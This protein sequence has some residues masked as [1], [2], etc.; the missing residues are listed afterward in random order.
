[1]NA[2]KTY[3]TGVNDR[4]DAF[5]QDVNKTEQAI[6][7][8]S[9]KQELRYSQQ[10]AQMA[11]LSST[12]GS[13]PRTSRQRSDEPIVIHELIM[14]K[15]SLTGTKS[16][17][18]I[19]DW[20]DD[21]AT[22]IEMITPGAKAILIEAEKM[23]SAIV[24]E[25]LIKH[26]SS[27][28]A[29]RVSREMF[30]VL[31][32][33]TSGVARSMIESLS[34]NDGL[35]AWGLI[36]L[37][38]CN[39][40]DQHIEAEY[41]V[42]C[43]I[44]KVAM[45]SMAGLADL[46]T[47]WEGE[48]KRFAAIDTGYDLSNLQKKNAVYE[49]LP[50]ELQRT[51]HIEV[52]KPGSNLK[53]YPQWIEFVKDWS[54]TYQFQQ[55]FKPTPLSTNLVDAQ[56]TILQPHKPMSNRNGAPN[57]GL[58]GSKMMKADITWHKDFL[59]LRSEQKPRMRSAVMQKGKGKGNWQFKGKGAGNTG[60]K[61]NGKQTKGKGKGKNSDEQGKFIGKCNR[62][63][64]NG[65]MARECPDNQ[66][67]PVEQYWMGDNSD[68]S[69]S[70]NGSHQSPANTNSVTLCHTKEASVNYRLDTQF[71]PVGIS[72]FVP[73]KTSTTF[74][75]EIVSN[76]ETKYVVDFPSLDSPAPP[77]GGKGK[78]AKFI[79]TSQKKKNLLK[80]AKRVKNCDANIMS[81]KKFENEI[82]KMPKIETQ[83]RDKVEQELDV[84]EQ[85]AKK[86]ED[87][88]SVPEAND[89]QSSRQ[90]VK[91]SNKVKFCEPVCPC[92]HEEDCCKDDQQ[93]K[94]VSDYDMMISHP[95][96]VNDSRPGPI[97]RTK[98]S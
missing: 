98:K 91:R 86:E 97:H 68:W 40:D 48:I 19:D 75:L 22:D 27:A 14:N 62:C 11:T 37:N 41:K 71:K 29:F 54:R 6:K 73:P 17:E 92:G 87:C 36:R 85:G 49:A 12:Q 47:R 90:R 1:M 70:S 96:I 39:N 64:K 30:C 69:G 25:D 77:Q 60:N 63:S 35:E 59:F 18:A 13:A 7:D 23:K 43:K 84:T 45:K 5:M 52:S 42:N 8:E 83:K 4:V 34:E 80:K 28:L 78:T 26:P 88:P 65:H 57:N 16:F 33:N 58:R 56:E 81:M 50:E 89:M 61:G 3:T 72:N 94:V 79:R 24:M 10:Q 15:E 93:D 9:N 32:K 53:A 67:N 51:I 20:Y 95:S 82:N 38:L 2:M 76:D 55:G 74:P 44:P 66:L 46:I 31:K 21:M